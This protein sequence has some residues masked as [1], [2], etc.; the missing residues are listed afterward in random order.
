[1]IRVAP[2]ARCPIPRAGRLHVTITREKIEQA[3]LDVVDR[4][5]RGRSR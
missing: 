2:L 1:M 5:G 3:V 4:L